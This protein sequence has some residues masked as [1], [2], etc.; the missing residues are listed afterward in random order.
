VEL[1]P[2]PVRAPLVAAMMAAWDFLFEEGLL[3]SVPLDHALTKV[4]RSS[5]AI[6][7]SESHVRGFD[8]VRDASRRS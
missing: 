4:V 7:E 5:A 8:T 1:Y 6:V 3:G 2:A